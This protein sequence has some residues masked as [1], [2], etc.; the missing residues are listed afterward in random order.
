M[1][2]VSQSSLPIIRSRPKVANAQPSRNHRAT[3]HSPGGTRGR[4]VM[5]GAHLVLGN[6]FCTEGI[7]SV[8]GE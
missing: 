1:G 3:K 2:Q 7:I 4:F 5:F 8:L 6:N